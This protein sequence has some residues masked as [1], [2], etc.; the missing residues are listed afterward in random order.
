MIDRK[1]EE[2]AMPVAE[3]DFRHR[4]PA[5]QAGY[6]RLGARVR[7]D[8]VVLAA[9]AVGAIAICVAAGLY[10]FAGWSALALFFFLFGMGA[11]MK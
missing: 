3:R 9:A 10:F 8:A 6:G 11:A 2:A 1:D 4:R 7:R 5:A